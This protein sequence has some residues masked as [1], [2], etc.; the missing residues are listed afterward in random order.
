MRKIGR[1]RGTKR[2]KNAELARALSCM[3]ENNEE[4]EIHPLIL[5]GAVLL[6]LVLIAG[7]SKG[8]SGKPLAGVKKGL[9]SLAD[10]PGA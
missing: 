9:E 5:I 3:K 10:L 1:S 7:M 4:T 2:H 8:G 6:A